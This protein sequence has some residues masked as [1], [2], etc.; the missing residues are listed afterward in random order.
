M[1]EDKSKSERQKVTRSKWRKS[2]GVGIFEAVT[3]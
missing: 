1:V 3:G 2:N